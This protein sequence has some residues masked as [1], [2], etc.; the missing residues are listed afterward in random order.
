VEHFQDFCNKSTAIYCTDWV[1]D[2]TGM[3]RFILDIWSQGNMHKLDLEFARFFAK[4]VSIT[5][6][7]TE[8]ITTIHAALVKESRAAHATGFVKEGPNE[9]YASDNEFIG[10]QHVEFYKIKPLMC[11]LIVVIDKRVDK[12]WDQDLLF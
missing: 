9:Y 10:G 7:T 4:L 1:T 12:M 8:E 11:A 2:F 3:F 6:K 5:A